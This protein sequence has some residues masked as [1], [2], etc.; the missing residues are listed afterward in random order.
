MNFATQDTLNWDV[1]QTPVYIK[2]KDGNFVQIQGQKALVRDDNR[3]VLAVMSDGYEVVEN[4][5]FKQLLN[6]LVSEGLITIENIGFLQGGKKVFLQAQMAQEYQVAGQTHK[7]FLTLLNS[8]NGTSHL[9]A[10][11]TS[12]RVICSNTFAMAY[13]NMSTKLRHKLGVKEEALGISET[14]EYV[15]IRMKEYTEDAEILALTPATDKQ[16]EDIFLSAYGKDADDKKPRNWDKLW[17]LYQQG[18]GNEGKTLWDAVNAITE[19]N[20]HHARRTS[21]GNFEYA[22]FGT[23]SN[24]SRRVMAHALALI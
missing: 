15:N 24:I 12:V 21:K 11:V 7:G 17:S 4:K 1:E 22:N 19:F 18:S 2:D 20:S 23:G 16:V 10:G 5:F 3:N 8:H 9:A 6:P 14:L 13:S